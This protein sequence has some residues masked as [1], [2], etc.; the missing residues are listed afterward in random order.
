MLLVITLGL[1]AAS[2]WRCRKHI[3]THRRTRPAVLV[4]VV[5]VLG[6]YASFSGPVA[7]A[8]ACGEA[9]NPQRPSDGLVGAIDPGPSGVRVPPSAYDSYGYAGLVWHTYETN[10][11]PLSG[12]TKPTSGFDTAF[13]NRLFDGAKAL[14]GA[15]NGLHYAVMNNALLAPID[16]AIETGAHLVYGNIY[17]QLLALCALL[18]VVLMFHQM[19]RGNLAAVSRRGL[20]TLAALWLAASSFTLLRFLGPF[21]TAVVRTTSEIQA[22]FLDD[23]DN[24]NTRDTL[25]EALHEQIVYKNWLRGEFGDPKAPQVDMKD[26][27]AVPKDQQARPYSLRLLDAQ[28]FTR[29]QQYYLKNHPDKVQ[30]TIDAKKAD[31]KDIAGKLGAATG[32]FTGENS[33]RAGAGALALVQSIL[34]ALFQLLVKLVVLIAQVLIRVLILTAPLLGLIALFHPDVL[35]KIAKL[36]GI[37]LFHLIVMSVLAGIHALLLHA[38]FAAGMPLPAQMAIAAIATLL[39]LRA[40]RP[41]RRLRQTLATPGHVLN[42]YSLS[43]VGLLKYFRRNEKNGSRYEQFLNSARETEEEIDS[44]SSSH[45]RPES[46]TSSQPTLLNR[47]SSL[48]AHGPLYHSDRDPLRKHGAARETH[49][50]EWSETL[51]RAEELG[52]EVELRSGRMTYAPAPTPGSPGQMIIDPDAS[53]GALR[54]EYQHLIDDFAQG[55]AGMRQMRDVEHAFNMERRAYEREIE[56]AES[57]GDHESVA[58]LREMIEEERKKWLGR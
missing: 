46:V 29:D 56:Y 2:A 39:F 27:Q 54:H 48:V 40:A 15:T 18:I 42:G 58:A 14:V 43:K 10:C 13:G 52:V 19:W 44:S 55:W 4:V 50:H 23:T 8:A 21:D 35:R 5:A 25:P 9:P 28:A 51:K 24:T 17:T 11:G 30:A 49:P 7:Y 12:L 57:I 26:P 6:C 16:H 32:Y 31:Y 3:L 45:A 38:T 33:G 53:I 34:Y 1:A 47:Q 37:V 36:G 20:Y 41:I 22:G